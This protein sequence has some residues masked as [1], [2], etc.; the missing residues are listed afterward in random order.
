MLPRADPDPT[1]QVRAAREDDLELLP[2]IQLAAGAA[3]R[4]V[5]MTAVADC[6]PLSVQALAA[7]ERAGHA[8][9]AVTGAD[10]PIGFMVVD[11]TVEWPLLRPPRL[12][13]HGSRRD[14]R[15]PFRSTQ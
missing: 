12:Q 13:G 3:F 4:D 10:V 11:L 15:R 1:T 7:Y 5:G 14:H 9:V 6:E 8:W 2:P